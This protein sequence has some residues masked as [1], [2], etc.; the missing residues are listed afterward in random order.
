M[1]SLKAK[2]APRTRLAVKTIADKDYLSTKVETSR[3]TRR[4]VV[5]TC[6]E[7]ASV[8]RVSAAIIPIE[9]LGCFQPS[10]YKGAFL[11]DGLHDGLYD[12]VTWIATRKG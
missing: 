7:T 8:L 6:S 11:H 9:N 12:I 10:V 1:V 4:Q 5:G 3:K 2:Q